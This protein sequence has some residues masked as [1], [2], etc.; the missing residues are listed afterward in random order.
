MN[1]NF[2]NFALN[3]LFASLK[4]WE[5]TTEKQCNRKSW[6]FNKNNAGISSFLK[7]FPCRDC[8]VIILF[9]VEMSHNFLFVSALSGL[10]KDLHF[11]LFPARWHHHKIFL[12]FTILLGSLESHFRPVETR[13]GCTLKIELPA[14]FINCGS[15]L[16]EFPK[17][18][19]RRRWNCF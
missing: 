6:Y 18:H 7:N 19:Q 2:N 15:L 10:F 8:A 13:L 11:P 1:R 17:S 16:P 3:K 9:F 12:P 5:I 14:L 4:S